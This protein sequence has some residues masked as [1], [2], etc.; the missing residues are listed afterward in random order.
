VDLAA[1]G[2]DV[3]A[4]WS[5]MVVLG[6]GLLGTGVRDKRLGGAGKCVSRVCVVLG[7]SEMLGWLGAL[8]C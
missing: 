7:G 2:L 3:R 8:P 5:G 4:S 6:Y 1:E